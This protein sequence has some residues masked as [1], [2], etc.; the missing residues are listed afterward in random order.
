VASIIVSGV[1]QPSDHPSLFR[2]KRSCLFPLNPHFREEIG[3]SLTA[4]ARRQ[5]SEPAWRL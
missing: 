1:R 3:L 4:R 2:W 5:A